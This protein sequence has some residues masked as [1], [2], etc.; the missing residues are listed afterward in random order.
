MQC[1]CVICVHPNGIVVLFLVVSHSRASLSFC[2]GLEVWRGTVMDS[3]HIEAQ[4][5]NSH[6]HYRSCWLQ[7]SFGQME[8][9]FDI[10][11]EPCTRMVNGKNIS[12]VPIHF[13]HPRLTLHPSSRLHFLIFP[14]HAC[15]S[16]SYVLASYVPL[17]PPH[18]PHYLL[19]SE[20]PAPTS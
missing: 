7:G 15:I 3:P 10:W 5:S 8:R 19:C 9:A 16:P 4:C 20:S 17:F 18:P 2:R 6:Y 11:E 1:R 13:S 12:F 14:S